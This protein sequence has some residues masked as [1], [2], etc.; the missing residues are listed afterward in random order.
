MSGQCAAWRTVI[1]VVVVR[2]F[3]STALG[4]VK[5]HP[6]SLDGCSDV[7]LETLSLLYATCERLLSWPCE[8][9]Q[10]RLIR[11]GK[12]SGGHRL[13]ALLNTL[14]RIWGR[15]R[16]PVSQAWEAQHRHPSFWGCGPARSSSDAAFAHN[17]DAEM[18][19]AVGDFSVSVLL[20]MYKCYECIIVARLLEEARA[21]QY[22]LRMVWMV[23]CSY[24]CPR[25]VQ[26]FGSLSAAVSTNQGIL[27][28]CSHANTM[29]H[30]LLHRVVAKCCT[31][32]P[33]I[34][35]RILM[36]DASFQWIGS[37]LKSSGPLLG[38]VQWFSRK[39][40]RLGLLLQV[41]KS[42]FVASSVRAAAKIGSTA[43]IIRLKSHKHMRNLG[44]EAP[45]PGAPS[46]SAGA[47]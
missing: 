37:D 14:V 12:P 34:S 46:A 47:Q 10:S 45:P 32:F 36:D 2:S 28:G 21:L 26:A 23:L 8:R 9:V 42:G 27:A 39:A 24:R 17:V 7:A 11:L 29:M 15:L 1:V 31:L 41:A 35:P 4:Q 13:I 40:S 43:K 20:D 44:H 19:R 25:V 38:A 3:S 22:P 5:I 6:K 33:T 16:R 18:A 30:L